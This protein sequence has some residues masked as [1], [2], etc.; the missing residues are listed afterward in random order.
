[1]NKIHMWLLLLSDRFW[2]HQRPIRAIACFFVGHDIRYSDLYTMEPDWCARCWYNSNEINLEEGWTIP[3]LLGS[4]YQ[5]LVERRW[6]WFDCL[7][8]WLCG[9]VKQLP[10][11]WRY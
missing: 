10:D 5:W 8:D 9:H 4:A 1:M 11:W 6:N 2:R 3:C 7:D